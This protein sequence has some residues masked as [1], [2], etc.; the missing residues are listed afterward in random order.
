MRTICSRTEETIYLSLCTGVKHGLLLR[1][2]NKLQMS[3][4]NVLGKI[5]GSMEHE[6]I[7]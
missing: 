7:S 3:G 4:N 5:F 1:L 2:K 6:V